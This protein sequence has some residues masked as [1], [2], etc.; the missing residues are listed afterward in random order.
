MLKPDGHD[1][2][3]CACMN[4]QQG[5]LIVDVS[6][7]LLGCIKQATTEATVHSIQ[8]PLKAEAHLPKIPQ[9]VL[10]GGL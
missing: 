4:T 6:A 8:L 10:C 9:L 7:T 2:A 3:P 1:Q 5:A